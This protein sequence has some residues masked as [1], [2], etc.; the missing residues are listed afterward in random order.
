M[1]TKRSYKDLFVI[2]GSYKIQR[3]KTPVIYIH[4]RD[5]GGIPYTLC[6]HGFRP[7]FYVRHP[8]NHLRI[9]QDL[10]NLRDKVASVDV[11]QGKKFT[12]FE[13]DLREV[14]KV[15]CYNPQ[16][17]LDARKY[18]HEQLHIPE[19]YEANV[20]FV[21]RFM[22]DY[23]VKPLMWI[24]V[25][26]YFFTGTL[27]MVNVDARQFGPFI[28]TRDFSGGEYAS[29]PPI[30]ILSFDIEVVNLRNNRFP[31]SEHDAITTIA[32][33]NY[34]FST[35]TFYKS[36]DEI[37]FQLGNCNTFA[38][39]PGATVRTFKTEKQ[40]LVDFCR[41]VSANRPDLITG[42][43]IRTFDIPYVYRRCVK[44]RCA[45][46]FNVAFSRYPGMK[47][48]VPD[49]YTTRGSKQT[50]GRKFLD[51]KLPGVI[52]ADMQKFAQSEKRRSYT[53]NFVANAILG[54][55]KVDVHHSQ[56]PRLF[57]GSDEERTTLAYYCL[58]DARL[59]AQIDAKKQFTFTC[60]ELTRATGLQLDLV[61]NAGQSARV[62]SMI[63]NYVRENNLPYLVPWI[64]ASGDGASQKRSKGKYTG[65]V[66]QRACTGTYDSPIV[67]HDFSSLYPSTIM[68][69]NLCYVTYVPGDRVKALYERGYKTAQCPDGRHYVVS[70]MCPGV[71]PGIEQR[72]LDARKKAKRELA[73]A[74]A[75]GDSAAAAVLDMRQLAFKLCANS[76]YGFV[77]ADFTFNCTA[78]AASVTAFGR[79]YITMA[80]DEV[81]K[82]WDG[83][84][85]KVIYGDTDSIMMKFD[86][87]VGL[88]R[89]FELGK[90]A[91]DV[92][93]RR[94][95][96]GHMNLLL[97]KVYYPFQLYTQKRYAGILYEKPDIDSGFV[98]H[99]GTEAKRR[100]TC[101]QVS[102]IVAEVI[103]RWLKHPA[104]REGL[105]KGVDTKAVVY[106][107]ELSEKDGMP[108]GPYPYF[109]AACRKMLAGEYPH[110]NF[111]MSSLLR[112]PVEAYASVPPHVYVAKKAQEEEPET[113]PAVGDR[114]PYVY[115]AVPG[116]NVPVRERA[117]DPIAAIRNGKKLDVIFYVRNQLMKSAQR[118]LAVQMMEMDTEGKGGASGHA[119]KIDAFNVMMR[120][121]KEMGG[122]YKTCMAK[123]KKDVE[124]LISFVRPKPGRKR[125]L[126][127]EAEMRELKEQYSECLKKCAACSH[128]GD[129]ISTDIED[130]RPDLHI[131]EIN[132]KD[133]WCGNLFKIEQVNYRL[134]RVY[135]EFERDAS[136][137]GGFDEGEGSV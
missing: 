117:A 11:V 16:T 125:H 130:M 79:K 94:I 97:E 74:K 61:V 6:V 66:V 131:E 81:E 89:A 70:D 27:R 59:P 29:Y 42:Y 23:G 80:K 103:E 134:R 21:Q 120:A 113:A 55:Q 83:V 116:R 57:K 13:P 34:T 39:A 106:D 124:Q 63:Y 91:Q 35:A 50:G 96:S 67:V 58:I 18:A 122:D 108:R 8:Y 104:F 68:Q 78:I 102:R 121:A 90:E 129:K 47:P 51:V 136:W 118:V 20:R 107:E 71:L 135:E 126:T 65:A 28:L 137:G 77:G 49:K 64:Q 86:E 33:H 24:S 132:C 15:T 12:E 54:Q 2:D 7:Y 43:N 45:C 44:R 1:A 127:A 30:R 133:V 84:G 46:A 114:V 62:M 38:E 3:D 73:A 88:E 82:R 22:I 92:L 115:I 75:A 128:T 25:P 48:R 37:V 110:E 9:Q 19:I 69:N 4:T 85:A 111:I 60:F 98:D 99:K 31:K 26:W 32:V 100:S 76:V 105:G 40:L 36:R 119:R 14:L 5:A 10:A 123:V 41:Y 112:Q 87:N 93:F 101:V 72:L 52:I 17:L 53:L 109:M 95:F 56:I